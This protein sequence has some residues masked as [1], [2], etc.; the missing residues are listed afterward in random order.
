MRLRTLLGIS[1]AAMA[2][3]P[4]P[5]VLG[6]EMVPVMLRFAPAATHRSDSL[7]LPLETTAVS[8]Q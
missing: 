7:T 4:T 1:F 8:S 2:A 3:L 5:W 6:D